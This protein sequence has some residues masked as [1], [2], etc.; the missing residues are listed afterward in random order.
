MIRLAQY[1]QGLGFVG[2]EN[3]IHNGIACGRSAMEGQEPSPP[4]M[5]YNTISREP[6]E[7]EQ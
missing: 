6:I 2:F 3:D 1:R 5:T 7:V 4:E